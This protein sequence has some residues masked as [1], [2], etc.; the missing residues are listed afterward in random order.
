MA[1]PMAWKHRA[2]LV[3]TSAARDILKRAPSLAMDVSYVPSGVTFAYLEHE[4]RKP[5]RGSGR[6]ASKAIP[7]AHSLA[8]Q[9]FS[10]NPDM[11]KG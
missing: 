1:G 2:N 9:V 4:I 6:C 10:G 5:W 8:E 7:A 11:I 3:A